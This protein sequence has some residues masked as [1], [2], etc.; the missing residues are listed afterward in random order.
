MGEG[1]NIKD[2]LL[3]HA[4]NAIAESKRYCLES[5]SHTSSVCS[6]SCMEDN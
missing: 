1:R 6:N 2:A 4:Y 3:C 5:L